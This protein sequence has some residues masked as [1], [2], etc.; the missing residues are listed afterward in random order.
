MTMPSQ[1]PASGTAHPI[2]NHREIETKLAA[3]PQVRIPSLRTVPGV[4]S[5]GASTT[6]ELDATY[7]DTDELDLLQARLTLRRRT[8]GH[9]AGWHLKMP[10]AAGRTELAVT[11]DASADTLTVPQEL[12]KIVHGAA[13]GA[14]LA[15]VARVHTT[16]TSMSLFDAA[17][18]ELLEIA[19]DQVTAGPPQSRPGRQ[20]NWREIEV[21]IVRG[22]GE[23]LESAVEKLLQ[24]GATP[25]QSVSKL[26][27]ALAAAGRQPSRRPSFLT[28]ANRRTDAHL[29]VLGGLSRYRNALVEGD[30]ALRLGSPDA[31]EGVR[32]I[33]RKLR[34]ALSVY[35]SM[36]EA[37]PVQKL[38]R[39][40]KS[41]HKLL[42]P[43]RDG[44]V[45]LSRLELELTE[46]P[47]DF[48]A[49]ARAVL[50]ARISED[51][52]TAVDRLRV[53]LDGPRLLQLLRDLDAFI[54][55]APMAGTRYVSAGRVLPA[56]VASS[57][58]RVRKMAD[59][60]LAAPDNSDRLDKV[61][62]SATSVRYAAELAGIALGTDA[63]VFAAGV[64]EIQEILT[65]Y[66]DCLLT[67]ELL[68]SLATD[69]RTTGPAGFVFGRMHAVAQNNVLSAY[70]DFADAWDRA[71]DGEISGWLG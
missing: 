59:V 60:A 41:L 15:P 58:A 29:V 40:L 3:G 43:I 61:R 36:F 56:L 66:R 47:I 17:G 62:R 8:G 9:D 65:E 30:I 13:R 27:A 35:R 21:E 51:R 67:A 38:A 39:E 54:A 63:V 68:V 46:E 71:D 50:N 45:L 16:R 55:D 5:V 33:L 2:N 52:H 32:T 22:T 34:S 12:A 6:F 23:Q 42:G 64:E 20:T 37:E 69:P 24:A 57:W 11:L 26:S 70:D 53:W 14:A 19:D 10:A 28:P 48:A 18:T 31:A 49:E 1:N 7:F 4:A 44:D 25:S